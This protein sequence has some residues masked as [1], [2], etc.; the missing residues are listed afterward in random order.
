MRWKCLLR[1]ILWVL[2]VGAAANAAVGDH[3]HQ[4]YGV[5][6]ARVLF[7]E[8]RITASW[9]PA[10]TQRNIRRTSGQLTKLLE[11]DENQTCD[12]W[13]AEHC[14][15]RSAMLSIAFHLNSCHCRNHLPPGKRWKLAWKR[16]PKWKKR[17]QLV[18]YYW[19]KTNRRKQSHS[20][21]WTADR[22]KMMNSYDM[23]LCDSWF[24]CCS[25][26]PFDSV[27]ATRQ[28]LPA[29]LQLA[30]KVHLFVEW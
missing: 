7:A 11:R 14:F 16:K 23:K 13:M 21:Q 9:L 17:N 30:G 28:L 26:F 1:Y 27:V 12:M 22:K 8:L 6:C 25:L 10:A 15:I 29:L 20:K 19:K 5:L 24:C 4:P 2:D 18:R 3:G